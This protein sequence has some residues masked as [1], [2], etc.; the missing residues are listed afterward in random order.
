VST[1]GLRRIILPLSSNVTTDI[2]IIDIRGARI[3]LGREE[4]FPG[5]LFRVDIRLELV[6][7][8]LPGEHAAL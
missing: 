5:K 7:P 6:K 8:F 3:F 2:R 1:S 4:A